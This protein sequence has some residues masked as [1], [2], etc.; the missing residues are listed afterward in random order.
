M[1][2]NSSVEIRDWLKTATG[3]L[4]KSGIKTARLDSLILLEDITRHDRSYILAYQE[5]TLTKSQLKTLDRLIKR[6]AQHEPLA[7][8]RK[9][10]NFYGR[11]FNV[12]NRVLVPRPETETMIDILKTLTL[13][14]PV[15]IADV[16]TGS[17]C[18]GLTAALE[19]PD[20]TIDLFDNDKAALKVAR[21]NAKSFE[22]KVGFYQMYLLETCPKNY[23]IILANL[24]YVPNNYRI[25]EAATYE[26]KLSIFGGLDGLDLYRQLFVQLKTLKE[27][28]KYILTESLPDQ[29]KLL[30]S[31]ARQSNFKSIRKEGY[32]QLFQFV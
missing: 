26:P 19:I 12:D 22:L 7:Y 31:I 5:L 2:T 8:I 32:I 21:N 30:A 20:A 29:H 16:G 23:D 9:L 10:S 28:P 1:N 15:N 11:K 3:I 4:Q 27:H 24:P 17:G 13:P 25:N 18:I 6:R 14:R